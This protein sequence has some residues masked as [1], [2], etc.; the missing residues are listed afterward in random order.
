MRL[1]LEVQP[2]VPGRIRVALQHSGFLFNKA[3][4]GQ[5]SYAALVVYGGDREQF[6]PAQAP[7]CIFDA[8]CCGFSR[9]A[10][11]FMA[12]QQRIA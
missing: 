8:A 2:E 6:F 9:I 12:R 5:E 1:G 10:L 3:Q 4:A 11:T 7:P